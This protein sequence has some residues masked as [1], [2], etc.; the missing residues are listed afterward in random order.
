MQAKSQESPTS[1]ERSIRE[2]SIS[3]RGNAVFWGFERRVKKLLIQTGVTIVGLGTTAGGALRMTLFT[4]EIIEI[5]IGCVVRAIS[6]TGSRISLNRVG[7]SCTRGTVGI[8]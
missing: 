5:V 1:T 8:G 7:I 3:T 6:H 2:G 4:D